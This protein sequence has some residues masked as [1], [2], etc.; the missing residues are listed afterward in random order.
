MTIK[1]STTKINALQVIRAFAFMA[2]FSYHCSLSALGSWGVSVFFILS[3]FVLTYS[4]YN[5]PDHLSLNP[6]SAIRFAAGKIARLYPLHLLM[7]V[8][9]IHY[10]RLLMFNRYELI[11]FATKLAANVT[12]TQSWIPLSDYYYSFN[13][14][15]WYL[16]DMVFLYFLFPYILAMLHRCRSRKQVIIIALS[17]FMLQFFFGCF[18]RNPRIFVTSAYPFSHWLTY[19]CPLFRSGDFLIGCSLGYLFLN[20]KASV[21]SV[22]LY[23]V[24]EAAALSQIPVIMLF[25]KLY[26]MHHGTS[27]WSESILFLPLTAF[28]VYIFACSQGWISRKLSS[29]K[30]LLFIAELSPYAYLIHF[31]AF[32]ETFHHVSSSMPRTP[33]LCIT[34]L[35]V[36]AISVSGS[37]LYQRV[38]SYFTRRSST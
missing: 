9:S 25:E 17:V 15:S 22:Q 26:I 32:R 23:T 5:R 14:L 35:I 18:L 1:Y 4:H 34:V 37:M 13:I 20:R 7:L 29:C 11:H 8:L 33:A 2:I 19:V 24:L 31:I 27:W 3:G 28:L 10:E 38:L 21:S 36:A 30:V 12:L 6:V 16:S